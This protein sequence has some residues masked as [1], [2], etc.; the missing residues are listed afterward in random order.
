MHFTF[1]NLTIYQFS[2]KNPS[3]AQFIPGIY[4]KII[5]KI[6]GYFWGVTVLV[7]ENTFYVPSFS[8]NLIF[9]SRLVPLGFSFTFPDKVFNLFYKSNHIGTCILVF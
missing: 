5:T 3:L 1:H 6:L 8:R 2:R 9:V 4:N 7:L